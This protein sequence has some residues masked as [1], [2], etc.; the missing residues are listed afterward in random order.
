VSRLYTAFQSST[1][2]RAATSLIEVRHR[3]RQSAPSPRVGVALA[4]REPDSSIRLLPRVFDG[5]ALIGPGMKNTRPG[6]P[7]VGQFRHPV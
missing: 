3:C 4:G 6:K 7:A 2:R 1:L 5:E